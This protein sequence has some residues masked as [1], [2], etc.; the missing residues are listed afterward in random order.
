MI[1]EEMGN[2]KSLSNPI[3]KATDHTQLSHMFSRSFTGE[4]CEG[5]QFPRIPFI[6]PE[7]G[8]ESAG[9]SDGCRFKF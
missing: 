1:T 8:R 9:E 7:W 6:T 3:K 4:Q 2:G 5:R